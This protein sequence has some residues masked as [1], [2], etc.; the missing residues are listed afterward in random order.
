MSLASNPVSFDLTR[1]IVIYYIYMV[2]KNN[3][4]IPISTYVS[5]FSSGIHKISHNVLNNTWQGPFMYYLQLN[6]HT[7]HF[8]SA[9]KIWQLLRTRLKA[10]VFSG[11]FNIGFLYMFHLQG[12][13]NLRLSRRVG[14]YR[15]TLWHTI[16]HVPWEDLAGT[17]PTM[18]C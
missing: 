3:M 1:L 18:K 2:Q 15:L 6:Q 5:T 4:G 16:H 11:G 13:A 10:V 12:A 17:N 7:S 8:L 14:I 9:P